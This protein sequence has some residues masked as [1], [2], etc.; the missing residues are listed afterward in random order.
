MLEGCKLHLGFLAISDQCQISFL[1]FIYHYTVNIIIFFQ[2]KATFRQSLYIV[3]TLVLG[4]PFLMC[5]KFHIFSRLTNY[6]I[7]FDMSLLLIVLKYF[8]SLSCPS[9]QSLYKN[10]H[11]N[12]IYKYIRVRWKK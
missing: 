2:I 11:Q 3:E 7:S 10:V 6:D 4:S 12:Y 8:P 5:L 1:C 9:I